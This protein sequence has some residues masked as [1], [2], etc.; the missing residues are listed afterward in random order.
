MKRRISRRAF[1][2]S[3]TV[4]IFTVATSAWTVKSGYLSTQD[5][6]TRIIFAI[7]EKRLS[8]LKWDKAQVMTFIK[9]FITYPGNQEYLEKVRYLSFFYPLYVH[10]GWLE[11]TSFATNKIRN[12]EERIVTQFLLSTN[13]FREGADET[14]PVKYLYYYD[15]YKTP[16]QNPF[17]QWQ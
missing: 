17:A 14:K 3:S 6:I 1:I 7:F 2:I 4:G 16:C 13:F 10:T 8:Y 12:F 15:P 9:D 11:S 5:R